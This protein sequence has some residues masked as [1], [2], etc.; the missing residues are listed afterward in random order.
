MEN[1]ALSILIKAKNLTGPGVKQAIASLKKFEVQTKSV[2]GRLKKMEANFKKVG[3]S[4]ADAGRRMLITSGAVVVGMKKMIDKASDLEESMTKTH[5]VF[6]DSADQIIAW[7]ETSVEAMGMSQRAALDNAAIFADMAQSM[8]FTTEQAI[9]M[10]TA[11]VQ[12]SADMASFHNISQ[13]RANIALKAIYTG[14]TEVLKQYGVVMTQA[15]LE[16]FALEQGITKSIKAMNQRELVMLREMFVF[17]KMDKVMGDFSRTSDGVANRQRILAAQFENLQAKI[18]ELLIPIYNALLDVGMKVISWLNNLDD[19]WKRI[20]LVIGAVVAAAG[21]MLFVFGKFI[22]IVGNLIKVTRI[23]TFGI[24]AQTARTKASTAA[25]SANTAATNVQSSAITKLTTKIR[26]ANAALAGLRAALLVATLIGIPFMIW[27]EKAKVILEAFG[28]TVK[29]IA[30]TIGLALVEGLHKGIG[31]IIALVNTFRDAVGAL[32]RGASKLPGWVKSSLGISDFATEETAQSW[33]KNIE[34]PLDSDVQALR[35]EYVKNLDITRDRYN[36]H[37]ILKRFQAIDAKKESEQAELDKAIKEAEE[38][39]KAAEEAVNEI[40]D[41]TGG[42]TGSEESDRAAEIAQQRRE[43]AHELNLRGVGPA[44][45]A[46]ELAQ[47]NLQHTTDP[48]KRLD[49]I[50]AIVKL[51]RGIEKMAERE[52]ARESKL[53]EEEQQKQAALDERSAL[54]EE[55]RGIVEARRYRDIPEEYRSEVQRQ[56]RLAAEDERFN[57][58]IS[59]LNIQGG[60]DAAESFLDALDRRAELVEEG[61]LG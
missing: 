39:S 59:E 61:A 5:A 56:D 53:A 32:A 24:Q 4:W 15:N 19:R 27:P 54:I 52:L 13:E 45:K 29:L 26:L 31:A 55:L 57:I 60:D 49:L 10:S 18:G 2:Q 48:Q 16:Q 21:P 47:F 46:L 22:G 12:L 30:D 20:I 14:E 36:E 28:A 58:I 44:Q 40:I 17:E 43:L 35:A 37:A 51:E 23:L 38:A 9:E 6:G 8:G 7:S 25:T 50:E 33:F 1:A 11:T 3:K 42:E 41:D 34:N